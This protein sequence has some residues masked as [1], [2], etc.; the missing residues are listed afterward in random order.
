MRA[1]NSMLEF[2]RLR[3]YLASKPM[4]RWLRKMCARSSVHRAWLQGHT[5]SFL[6]PVLERS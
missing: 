3:A 4:P 5:G 2:I 1:N 6:L